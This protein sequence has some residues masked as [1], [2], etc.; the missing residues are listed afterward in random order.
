MIQ[1]SDLVPATTYTIVTSTYSNPQAE[2]YRYVVYFYGGTFL[3]P[4]SITSGEVSTGNNGTTVS[5]SSQ[6]LVELD[7]STII[8]IAAGGTKC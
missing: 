5:V 4:T 8:A 3:D 1:V 6:G 2:G 7:R